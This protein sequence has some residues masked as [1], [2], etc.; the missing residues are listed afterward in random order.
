MKKLTPYLFE[1]IEPEINL[2]IKKKKIPP[3]QKRRNTFLVAIIFYH[4]VAFAIIYFFGMG[5]RTLPVW[6][7]LV[8][9]IELF[10]IPILFWSLGARTGY[11]E[12]YADGIS[13]RPPMFRFVFRSWTGRSASGL[14]EFGWLN[15]DEEKTLEY[16]DIKVVYE[17]IRPEIEK[18]FYSSNNNE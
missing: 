3:A 9:M 16:E 6:I 4:I 11:V 14:G 1:G 12:G 10:F 5:G 2:I 13:R 17:R 15:D 8:I 18:E 7:A